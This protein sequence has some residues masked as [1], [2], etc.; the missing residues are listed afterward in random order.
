MTLLHVSPHLKGN[1]R[2]AWRKLIEDEYKKRCG[3]EW[4]HALYFTGSLIH[5]QRHKGDMF[6]WNNGG[7][8]FDKG[9]QG[10]PKCYK[11]TDIQLGIS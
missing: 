2:K 11:Y 3:K 10:A 4:E 9:F 8:W 1:N 5:I 6:Q 7:T